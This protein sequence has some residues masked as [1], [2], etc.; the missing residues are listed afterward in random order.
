MKK[1]HFICNGN[2]YRSRIAEA[3]WNAKYSKLATATSSGV[4]QIKHKD[5]YGPVSWETIYAL[6]LHGITKYCK[7]NSTQ[8]TEQDIVQ[9]DYIVL[10]NDDVLTN[11]QFHINPNS[12]FKLLHINDQRDEADMLTKRNHDEEVLWKTHHAENTFTLISNELELIA[13]N[14]I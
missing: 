9:N 5:E 8:T 2:L 11:F 10:M 4:N 12:V 6:R 7:P 1:I 14:I 3:I 13:K